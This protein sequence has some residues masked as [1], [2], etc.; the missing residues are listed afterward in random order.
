LLRALDDIEASIA[1][2]KFYR[3]NIFIPLEP[4]KEKQDKEKTEEVRKTAL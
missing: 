2:L 4:R 1:E 3:D